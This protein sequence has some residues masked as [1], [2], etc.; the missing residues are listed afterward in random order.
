MSTVIDAMNDNEKQR[1]TNSSTTAFKACRKK[2][3]WGYELGIRRE[4][5]AKAL[6]M[7]SNYHWGLDQLKRGFSIESTLEEL[8]KYLTAFQPTAID[9]YEWKIE[10]QTVYCLLGAYV[11]RWGDSLKIVESEFEFRVPLVNTATGAASKLFDLAGK[12][13]GI[14]DIGDGRLATLEHKLIGQDISS[15]SDYWRLLQL[16]SQP[17][18]YIKAAREKGYDC[19]TCF[20]DLTRKPTIKPCNVPLVDENQVKI[21]LDRDGNRVRNATGKFRQTAD[22]DQGFVLQTRPMTTKEWSD[23]L[24]ND[25]SERPD[26]YFHRRE[27]PR[28]DQEI[29]EYFSELWEIQ[30]T[31]RDAQNNGRWYKTVTFNTCP[32]CPYYSLCSSHY[33]PCQP[34][35]EGFIKTDNVHQE[36]GETDAAA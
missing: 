5:D 1:L 20:Y 34:L 13:D 22:K 23:K 36:L 29:N 33:D 7:G 2:Y 16:D 9:D 11:W 6:R 8:E 27:V 31:I 4:V 25:I 3:W 35:P 10:C 17:T 21:V 30:K 18:I 15:E 26:F 14:I 24:M 28:L 32:F 12:I 19:S